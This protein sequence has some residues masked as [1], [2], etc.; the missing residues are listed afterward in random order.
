M[1][2]KRVTWVY[3][4]GSRPETLEVTA[5]PAKAHTYLAKGIARLVGGVEVYEAWCEQEGAEPAHTPDAA[6]EDGEADP[7]T[8]EPSPSPAPDEDVPT[9]G[10]AGDGE[11]DVSYE[12]PEDPEALPPGYEASHGGGGYFTLH[13][14]SG[15]IAGPSNGKWQG[16]DATADAAWADFGGA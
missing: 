3:T 11:A 8:A 5:G 14:P 6:N 9:A 12:R 2:A 16:L 10:P 4:D 1:G 13:G 15:A 7:P